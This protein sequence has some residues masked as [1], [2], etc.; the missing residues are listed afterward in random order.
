MKRDL[1]LLVQVIRQGRLLYAESSKKPLN[2]TYR[3]PHAVGVLS[4]SELLNDHQDGR[5]PLEDEREFTL[6]LYQSDERD[7]GTWH[8]ELVAKKSTSKFSLLPGQISQGNT[9]HTLS[10]SHIT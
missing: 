4:L 8:H 5:G 1:Y 9:I 6:K 3:R 2:H 10:D 7:Y